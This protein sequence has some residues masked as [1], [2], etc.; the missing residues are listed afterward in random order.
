MHIKISEHIYVVLRI[1]LCYFTAIIIYSP[2]HL[3]RNRKSL[4]SLS[5]VV[6]FQ[7]APPDS[8][9]FYSLFY[10][11]NNDDHDNVD[12]CINTLSFDLPTVPAEGYTT[13]APSVHLI[14]IT[15]YLGNS[16]VA[17]LAARSFDYSYSML[18]LNYFHLFMHAWI[19]TVRVYYLIYPETRKNPLF[20]LPTLPFS[21]VNSEEI[22]AE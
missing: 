7:S 4:W 20:R 6:C 1:Y 3:A 9:T 18:L 13:T 16:S 17:L 21:H 22:I 14:S 15:N 5:Q 2:T 12:Y 8:F 10:P 11:G 19:V